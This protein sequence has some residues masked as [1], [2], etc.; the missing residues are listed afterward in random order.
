[1]TVHTYIFFFGGGAGGGPVGAKNIGESV[2]L[3]MLVKLPL[4]ALK[5]FC[6]FA[7]NSGLAAKNYQAKL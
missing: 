3:K 2:A 7:L 1:L 5:G 6:V 4:K